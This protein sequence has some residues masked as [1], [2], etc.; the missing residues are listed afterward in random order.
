MIAAILSLGCIGMIAAVA[1]GFAA[2]KFAVEVDPREL[3]ALE[4]LPG[5]NCGACGFPGCA[6]Y[7]K[8]VIAGSADLNQCPPGG[9]EVVARLARILGVEATAAARQIAVVVCQ[10]DNQRAQLKYRYL[11]LED[12]TAAQKIADGPKACPGGCLGLGSCQQA[13]PFGAIEMTADGLAV[14]SREKCTGCRK[15]LAVCPRDVIRMTPYES[16]VHVLC[17]SH[18]KGAVVRKYCQVGCIGCH[19]CQKTV[20][21]AYKI[22]NFLAAVVYEQDAEA[23][24]A[25]A[26]CPTKCIRDFNEG[27]PAGSTFLPAGNNKSDAA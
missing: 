25:I 21:Q 9:A 5:I 20:P 24:E 6:G 26:K 1:L 19:I 22:E 3:A 16:A 15:C 11:G 13:C 27:Y 8:A 14:I 10:G 23:F 7:A 4:V 2:K 17:N 18:D 12:C